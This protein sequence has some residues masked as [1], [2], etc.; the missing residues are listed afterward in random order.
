MQ[1]RYLRLRALAAMLTSTRCTE[2]RCPPKENANTTAAH[3]TAQQTAVS[4]PDSRF[5]AS[6]PAPRL[7]L[8]QQQIQQPA[9]LTRRQGVE[10]RQ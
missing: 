10:A 8:G 2:S 6:P 5:P 9:A 7:A 1:S 4:I 3:A